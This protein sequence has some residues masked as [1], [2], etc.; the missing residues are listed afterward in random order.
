MK[1]LIPILGTAL[2]MVGCQQQPAIQPAPVV[3]PKPKPK[4]HAPKPP[5][6]NIKLKEVEDENFSSEY[7]YPETNKKAAKKP[8]EVITVATENTSVTAMTN[9]ECISMIGR[10][11]FEKYSQMFGG[12][13]GALKKCKMLKAL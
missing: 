3:K 4:A 2:I 11:K 1:S 12:D 8:E 9:E 6:K 10:E 5:K 7:M 13:A